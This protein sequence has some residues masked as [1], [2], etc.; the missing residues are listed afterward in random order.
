M[1]IVSKG[2]FSAEGVQFPWPEYGKVAR[3]GEKIVYGKFL[4]ILA[5]GLLAFGGQVF[6]QAHDPRA[7]S[8]DPRTATEQI[9]P[10]LEGL[11]D[12]SMSVTTS[13]SDSQYFFDQGLRLTYGFNHSEAMRA[14]K[15]AIRLDPNNAMAYWGWALV[16]G[17]N[18]NLPMQPEV[19]PQAYEAMN[20]AIAL[21]GAVAERERDYIDSLAVR[22]SADPEQDRAPLDAAYAEAMANLYLQY[23]DDSDAATLYA[24]SLM[25]LSPWNYWRGDGSPIPS[26][27]RILSVLEGVIA[28]Y[29]NHA[30]ARHYYIHLVEKERASL[31]EQAADELA[32]LAPGAGHLVH[33]PAHI[34]MRIGRYADSYEANRL[35]SLADESYIAQCQAQGIYPLGYYP[36]NVHFLVWSAMYQG[37]S[38]AALD[39]ARRVYAAIPQNL[40]GDATRQFEQFISQPLVAMV[41]FGDWQG[42]LSE[43]KPPETARYWTGLWHYARG[44]ARINTAA[45]TSALNELQTLRS[46]ANEPGIDQYITF[47]SDAQSLLNIAVEILAGEIE[48]RSGRH[49][50]AISHLE[51]AVRLQETLVYSEPPEW[52]FPSR[53]YLGAALL[54][55]EY[56]EEA[57]VVYWA[58]LRDHPENGY[59]LFGLSQA[60]EAQ[61]KDA[62]AEDARTRFDAAWT[63][64]DVALTSSRF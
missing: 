42:V 6:A 36:H 28:D 38:A 39:A 49:D 23:P 18:I 41:R 20:Q 4:V 35:A 22:Y 12:H 51:R 55:A 64:A 16:L 19:V 14:F 24:A 54:D 10:R 43:P 31:A 37:R 1:L 53:H 56:S 61:G 11:G 15:E 3:T 57:E 7:L 45:P 25:N 40:E 17:P 52:Y 5:A 62:L 30:G 58:D 63:E 46:I 32:L 48:S 29:P 26:T 27:Q 21:K 2:I 8:A 60:L 59:S 44:L 9:A 13:S 34:Y 47:L 50:E 33:M